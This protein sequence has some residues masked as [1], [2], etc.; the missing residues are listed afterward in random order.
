MFHL[1]GDVTFTDEGLQILPHLLL[2]GASVYNGHLRGPVTLTSFTERLAVE[3]LLPVFTTK[4]C[5]DWDSKTKPNLPLRSCI[6]VSLCYKGYIHTCR[7]KK[8]QV[9]K[10]LS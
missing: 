5:R 4:V 2:Y 1:N 6:E 7:N 10:Q 9:C 8:K 3:L